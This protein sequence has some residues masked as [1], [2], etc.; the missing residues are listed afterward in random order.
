[1]CSYRVSEHLIVLKLYSVLINKIL[2]TEFIN[3]KRF[4]VSKCGINYFNTVT[5]TT[6]SWHMFSVEK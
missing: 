4:T 3:V 5:S 2:V 1:M 6:Y